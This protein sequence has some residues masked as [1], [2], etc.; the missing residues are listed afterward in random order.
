MATEYLTY[1]STPAF[2]ETPDGNITTFTF[3]T[4]C[5]EDTL[6]ILHGGLVWKD[7]TYTDSTT[8]EFDVAPPAGTEVYISSGFFG[9]VP[10][11]TSDYTDYIARLV[12][13]LQDNTGMLSSG[14]LILCLLN[15]VYEYSRIR[16][17]RVVEDIAGTDLYTLAL[18]AQWELDISR[19]TAIEMILTYDDDEEAVTLIDPTAYEVY[20]NPDESLLRSGSRWSSQYT[21][22]VRYTISQQFAPEI[23]T[24]PV[25][26][27]N[28]I[29]YLA[30]S[31]ACYAIAA[32]ANQ[33]IDNT[34]TG[35]TVDRSNRKSEAEIWQGFA[36]DYEKKWRFAMGLPDKPLSGGAI[37]S[38]TWKRKNRKMLFH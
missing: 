1:P 37:T 25:V 13:M 24:I 9:T 29:I 38:F 21:Y 7:I 33:N 11:V 18:P 35:A 26:D 10:A 5:I 22:R 30:A 3:D 15:A 31:D 8:I 16:P 14:S 27:R 2:N 23:V 6:I 34:F 32:Y 4:P 17:Q 19:V 28:A 12:L 20:V 36:K